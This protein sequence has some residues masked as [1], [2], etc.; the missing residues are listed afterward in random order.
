MPTFPNVE[1]PDEFILRP[2][3][4]RTWSR[5][6]YVL[7][8]LRTGSRGGP[9]LA[10]LGCHLSTISLDHSGVI[11]PSVCEFRADHGNRTKDAA[12]DEDI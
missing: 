6:A 10:T 11:L 5:G 1:K 7:L 9:P 8:C 3:T 4:S 12:R 2:I